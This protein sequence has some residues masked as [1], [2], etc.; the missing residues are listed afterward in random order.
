MSW[1]FNQIP[2]NL[3]IW[4]KQ[5]VRR[6]TADNSFEVV[7]IY[8]KWET[9][10]QLSNKV[11][12]ENWKGLSTND[13]TTTEKNKLA[14]IKPWAEVNTINSVIAWTNI[15]IDNTDPL[16]PIISATWLGGWSVTV[17]NSLTW[18]QGWAA[19]DYQH[20]TTAQ[21]TNLNNQSWTNTWDQ[22]MSNWTTVVATNWQTVCTTPTYVIWNNK[23]EVYLNWLLQEITQDYTET[24]TT[25]ITFVSWLLAWDRVTYKLLS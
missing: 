21:V 23:L 13:Y 2:Y 19:W 17:H 11:D 12:K 15:H 20:L 7:E 18:I 6:N 14:W 5:T 16:N 8:S 24:S 22:T 1:K 4:S 3:D 10:T 9:D 25:S